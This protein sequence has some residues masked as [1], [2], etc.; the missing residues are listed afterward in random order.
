MQRARGID[1]QGGGG[2]GAT[3]DVRWRRRWQRNE[4]DKCEVGCEVR[5]ARMVREL[6][7][8]TAVVLSA[9]HDWGRVSWPR[10]AGNFEIV[11]NIGTP[12][13]CDGWYM[14]AS[15]GGRRRREDRKNV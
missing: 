11:M 15:A 2:G 3:G 7:G 9:S 8:V 14:H 4:S 12:P 13:R 5:G 10:D 6:R 1:R